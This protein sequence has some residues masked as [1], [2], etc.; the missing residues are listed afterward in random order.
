MV[1]SV[2][3]EMSLTRPDTFGNPLTDLEILSGIVCGATGGT[4]C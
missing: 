1:F 3:L 4:G 2:H